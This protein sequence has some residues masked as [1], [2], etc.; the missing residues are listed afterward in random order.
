MSTLD[1]LTHMLFRITGG[2]YLRFAASSLVG[3]VTIPPLV[4]GILA[5]LAGIGLLAGV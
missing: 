1:C 3:V 4:L 2:L 5:I